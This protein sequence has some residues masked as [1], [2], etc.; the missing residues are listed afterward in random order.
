MR[1]SKEAL[2]TSAD[3]SRNSAS[4]NSVKLLRRDVQE[5][6]DMPHFGCTEA[7]RQNSAVFPGYRNFFLE[8]YAFLCGLGL[9]L[10]F[11]TTDSQ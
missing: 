2:S 10:I 7:F 1:Y 4:S 11:Q 9:V 8:H 6:D 5:S 3:V